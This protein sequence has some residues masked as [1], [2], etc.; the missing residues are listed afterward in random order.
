M[1]SMVLN[2]SK[3]GDTAN[4]L[5]NLFQCSATLTVEQVCLCRNKISCVSFWAHCP[6][7]CHWGQLRLVL[8]PL[9]LLQAEQ[10]RLSL[11]FPIWQMVPARKCNCS[12]SFR[13]FQYI[14]DYIIRSDLTKEIHRLC[15]YLP[16]NAYVWT[17]LALLSAKWLFSTKGLGNVIKNCKG[18]IA[19]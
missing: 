5:V 4:A 1:S 14:T 10:Q 11:P 16:P 7:S 6:L 15:S 13:N 8:R 9:S 2:I 3:D 19:L 18:N 12:N 17:A